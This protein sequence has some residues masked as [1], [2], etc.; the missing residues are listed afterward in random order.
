M[1]VLQMAAKNMTTLPFRV[2]F[3]TAPAIPAPRG[4]MAS[5]VL[6]TAI[7]LRREGVLV[8]WIAG[9]PVTLNPGAIRKRNADLK[10]VKRRCAESSIPL[11]IVWLPPAPR[12]LLL[13]PVFRRLFLGAAAGS[14]YKSLRHEHDLSAPV[15]LHARSYFATDLA[16]RIRNAAKNHKIPV[17][18]D[19][20]SI[21]PEE[22]AMQKPLLGRLLFASLKEW[23]L[24]LLEDSDYA[25]LPVQFA[26]DRIRQE[27]GI[28]VDLIRIQGFDRDPDWTVDFDRRWQRRALGFSGSVEPWHSPDL[29][30]E[31]CRAIPD[32][33]GHFATAARPELAEF[34]CDTWPYSE[35]H[36]YYDGLLALIVPG[37][38]RSDQRS[39]F[40]RFKL[41]CNFFATKASEALSRGVPLIVSSE[42]AELADFVC[43][44]ECG[45]VYDPIA[46]TFNVS[47]K[48][49]GARSVWEA[50]T[51]NAIDVGVA[52]TRQTVVQ[53][54]LRRWSSAT[55]C[56]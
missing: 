29:L 26:A 10:Q 52:F 55:G 37:L 1:P 39:Y 28:T 42:L 18:F 27:S 3:V 49:L 53:G 35:M 14:A 33:A 5:Q 40:H 47:A 2:V 21:F 48:D 7:A 30:A 36:S 31:I 20:R 23:E 9:I 45:F 46:K 24:K 25:F 6:E 50:A 32:A 12:T 41:R 22:V 15:I 13:L 43:E 54:Y 17:S 34:S 4:L 51:Q 56:A 11:S 38:S 19:M 8:S 44:H 16:L